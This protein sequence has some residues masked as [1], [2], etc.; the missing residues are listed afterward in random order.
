MVGLPGRRAL[1]VVDPQSCRHLRGVSV[2]PMAADRAFLAL[3]A[4]RGIAD[5][6]LAIIDRLED[7]RATSEEREQLRRLRAQVRDWRR[8]RRLR[9]STRSI[10]LVEQ[11]GRETRTSARTGRPR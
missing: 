10:I 2:I 7:A 3:E 11:R 4:E 9:F 1:I 5:L 8:S 6:E